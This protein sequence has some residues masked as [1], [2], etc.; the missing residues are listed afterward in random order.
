M[1]AHTA[2]TGPSIRRTAATRGCSNFSREGSAATV[3]FVIHRDEMTDF[4]RLS[5]DTNPLH[6]DADFARR[7]GFKDVVVYGGLILAHV[8]RLLGT[9]LPGAGCVW[10]SISLNFRNPLYVDETARV[11]A[12]VTHSNDE[13]AVI[14]ARILVEAGGRRIAEGEAAAMLGAVRHA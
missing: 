1:K 6:S 11:T 4:E 2:H 12:T 9:V 7:S 13:L 5:G 3:E 14:Q 8:S 10:R